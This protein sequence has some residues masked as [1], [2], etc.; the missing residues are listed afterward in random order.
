MC[1]SGCLR[2]QCNGWG[3]ASRGAGS[4]RRGA[5]LQTTHEAD[6]K[7]EMEGRGKKGKRGIKACTA[8]ISR[9]GRL[10]NRALEVVVCGR[11]EQ[12]GAHC[13]GRKGKATER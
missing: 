1:L 5:P 3:G 4:A 8:A 11:Q 13:E 6:N 10:S 12:P 2:Q 9:A 7:G